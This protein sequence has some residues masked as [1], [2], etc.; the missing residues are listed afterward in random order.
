MAFKTILT[1]TGPELGN[2]DLRLAAGLC[3]EVGAH[4]SVM[5]MAFAA[6][7]PVGDYA[8]MVSDV[9]LEQRREDLKELEARSA[10][11]AKFLASSALSSETWQTTT[12]T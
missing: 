11:V 5:V 9:W 10:A 12:R 7:P 6:P 2:G 1:I 3:E 4:L 8:V